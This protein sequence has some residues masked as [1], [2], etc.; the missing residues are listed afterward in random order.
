[1]SF[2]FGLSAIAILWALTAKAPRQLRIYFFAQIVY[3]VIMYLAFMDLVKGWIRP[4]DYFIAYCVGLSFVAYAMAKIVLEHKRGWGSIVFSL[5]LCLTF[6]GAACFGIKEFDAGAWSGLI[7]GT[8]LTF[9]GTSLA[10][11]I[12]RAKN[13]KISAALVC[14][15][16]VLAFFDYAYAMSVSGTEFWNLWFRTFAV[17]VAMLY[18]GHKLRKT[19]IN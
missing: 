12:P 18:L 8:I 1:M 9:C 3:C 2:S 17:I 10:L 16:L 4:V 13:P 19:A 6:A 11:S 14:L 7:E 5:I 15:W